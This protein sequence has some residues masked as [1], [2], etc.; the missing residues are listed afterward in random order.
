MHFLGLKKKKKKS[1]FNRVLKKI[2]NKPNS[3]VTAFLSNTQSS[4]KVPNKKNKK[5]KI[6]VRPKP[7]GTIHRS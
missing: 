1:V 4:R 5:K 2:D 7:T 3:T 6:A